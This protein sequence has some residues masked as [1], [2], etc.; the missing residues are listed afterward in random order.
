MLKDY[1]DNITAPVKEF[2]M[3]EN[4]AHSPIYE[5]PNKAAELDGS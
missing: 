5:E 4:S 3:F 1:Y 2:Y